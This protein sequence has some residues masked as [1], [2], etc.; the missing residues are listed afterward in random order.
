MEAEA[1]AAQVAE[2]A[3]VGRVERAGG[4]AAVAKVESEAESEEAQ[5]G[6]G[7]QKSA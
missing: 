7:F 6:A 3:A 2:R 4:L 5:G 1:R